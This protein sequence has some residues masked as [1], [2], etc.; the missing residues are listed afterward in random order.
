MRVVRVLM[1]RPTHFDVDYIIN[2]HMVPHSVDKA[3]AMRQWQA[4]VA[5]LERLGIQVDVIEQ[6][7]DAPDMVFA[8]DQAIVQNGKAFLANFRYPERKGETKYYRE[9]FKAHGFE[10]REL[11]NVFS[12]EG[13]DALFVG[14]T[15]FVGTGFRANVGSCEE[16][17][18]ALD[19]DVVPLRLIDPKFYHLDMCFLPI[20]SDA[21]FYYPPAFSQNSQN[22][23]K[24]LIPDLHEL[25][26][27]EAEGY[28]A[29]SFV[30]DSMV[31]I[32]S[33]NPTFVRK[34][35]KLDKQVIELDLSEFKKAGGGIH[36][37]INTLERK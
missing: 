1:C 18:Q 22:I 33:G 20:D 35:N 36:C 19:T 16:L 7:P 21:A 23:L 30:T 34:L 5:A 25:T 27:K 15:L 12:F 31:V 2:P 4:L 24:K 6:A 8:T 9:W 28:A 13:G 14:D 3:K 32:Q 29:N 11:T 17:S 37:L 26:R 10:P